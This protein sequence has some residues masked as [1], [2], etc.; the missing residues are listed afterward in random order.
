MGIGGGLDTE[1]LQDEQLLG[2]VREVVVAAD[3]VRDLHLGVI[4][5]HRQVVED[6]TV[7]SRYHRIVLEAVLE[8]DLAAQLVMLTQRMAKNANTMLAGDL[9]DPEVAFLLGK[10]TNT[11]R[12]T[13]QGLLQGS[14]QAARTAQD[15]S[16][17][18]R[19]RFGSCGDRR[20]TRCFGKARTS[21]GRSM[22]RS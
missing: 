20:P 10:D 15:R 18:T 2:R 12:D 21:R 19:T 5:R 6:R 8:P 1:R 17:R 7:R 11:F 13:L 14:E 22:R 3:H 9:V 16:S 4:D